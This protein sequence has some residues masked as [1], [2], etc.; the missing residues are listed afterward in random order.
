M[1]DSYLMLESFKVYTTNWL[2]LLLYK[3]TVVNLQVDHICLT[4]V[5]SETAGGLPGL[6]LSLAGIKNGSPESTEHVDIWGPPN[7][8]LLV[9]AMKNFVP[10][11]TMVKAHIIP[12][13][14]NVMVHGN[15]A[16]LASSL[17]AEELQA[18]G[19]FKAVSISA[20]LLTPTHLDGSHF[21]SNDTSIVYICN[22][23][24][25]RGE[26]DPRKAKACGLKKG[27]KLG[28]LQNGISVKSDLLDIEVC[29]T[30]IRTTLYTSFLQ[31]LCL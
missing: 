1:K 14:D 5:C 30:L 27:R 19:K 22:L 7:L 10:H 23:H 4:R 9:N 3:H 15:G 18:E 24:D 8:D 6:L 12:R 13:S 26:F 29:S 25:I 20:I 17:H 21:S 28:Q 2:L 16:A 11:A 31:F